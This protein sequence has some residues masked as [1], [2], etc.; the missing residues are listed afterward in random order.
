MNMKLC[1]DCKHCEPASYAI[2]KKYLLF[3]PMVVRSYEYAK[4]K[5]P[6]YANMVTGAGGGYCDLVR[7]FE[8]ECGKEGDLWEPKE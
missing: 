5:A 6:P 4:C 1:K 3:G 2:G 7:R 8:R